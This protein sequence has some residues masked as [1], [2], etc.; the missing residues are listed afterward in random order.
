M[1]EKDQEEVSVALNAINDCLKAL[2][3]RLEAVEKYVQ[4]L[5]TPD[6][7]YYKPEGQDEYLNIKANYDQIY[8]RL[9]KLEDGM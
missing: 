8:K 2:H 3:E 6:K 9:K 7:T 1:T 4:E 5:P